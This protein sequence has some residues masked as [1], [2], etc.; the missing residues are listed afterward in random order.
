MFKNYGYLIG[1]CEKKTI[2]RNKY[3]K[4][5]SMNISESN[6][7]TFRHKLTLDELICN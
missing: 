5:V 7:L 1:S 2:L 3:T 4:N 6:T